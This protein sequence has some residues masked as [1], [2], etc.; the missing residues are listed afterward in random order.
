MS[1]LIRARPGEEGEREPLQVTE[2]FR[3]QVVHHALAH[4]VREEGLDHAE[5]SDG[6]SDH[7]HSRGVQ[8][9]RVRVVCLQRH[10]QAAEQ[11]RGHD[12]EARAHDD[13]PE[14]H[15]EPPPVRL[16]ERPDPP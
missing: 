16:E 7:D 9:D 14:Q 11:E 8:G 3:A 15:R 10:E 12:P 2:D 4:L 5:D 1:L 6:D 13:Q